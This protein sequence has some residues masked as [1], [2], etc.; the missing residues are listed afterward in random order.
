MGTDTLNTSKCVNR[1]L[2]MVL[3]YQNELAQAFLNFV[4]ICRVETQRGSRFIEIA[5]ESPLKNVSDELHDCWYPEKVV[6]AM[7]NFLM[8][9]LVLCQVVHTIYK[10]YNYRDGLHNHSK[11]KLHPG[12]LVVVHGISV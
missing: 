5:V 3:T 9:W 11:G 4:H 12:V 1:L 6:V 8:G 2:S 7:I 10:N